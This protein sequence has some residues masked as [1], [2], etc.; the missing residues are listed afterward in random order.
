MRIFQVGN[1][2]DAHLSQLRPALTEE[3]S[4]EDA[5]KVILGDVPQA[6]ILQACME[7]SDGSRLCFPQYEPGLAMWASE[8]CMASG[9]PPEDILCAMIEESGAEVFY[10]INATHHS[11]GFMRR[12]PGC[13]RLRVG[14]LGSTNVGGALNHFDAIVSN[15]PSLN[16]RHKAD[17]LSTHYITP[18][19]ETQTD[20]FLAKS[21]PRRT[22]IFFG[23][24]YSRHH[25]R[26]AKMIEAMVT[27]AEN[28]N[29]DVR[30]HLLS[31]RYTA[32]AERT[33][34]GWVQPFRAVRRPRAVRKATKPPIFGA[35]MFE[36]LCSSKIVI[37]MAVDLAGP[38][39]GNMRCFEA[40]SAGAVMI[41]DD[42]DYPDG[43]EAGK[44]HLCYDTI[45][46]ALDLIET[47]LVNPE[48]RLAVG[49]AGARMVRERYS[50]NTQWSDFL[51]LCARLLE[52]PT[53]TVT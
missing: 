5:H 50:K 23:G 4:Y 32:L 18:S 53:E 25:T 22:D 31:S 27:W 3:R 10:S 14:W 51:T 13:V 42:G 47:C 30:L 46:T 16:A 20:R 33:P 34:L 38:D 15:F 43:F 48:M 45:D 11:E 19:Y 29:A 12:L 40:V 6:L 35:A 41:S 52:T 8:H 28:N 17:G 39:R 26:R 2:S 21:A 49:N 36:Q 37:N 1:I 7:A 9:S 24:T 44:T